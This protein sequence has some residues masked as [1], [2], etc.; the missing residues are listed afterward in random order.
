M[1]AIERHLLRLLIR[2]EL[3][4]ERLTELYQT[5]NEEVSLA[6]AGS[7]AATYDRRI[8]CR[9]VPASTEEE[10]KSK[11]IRLPEG[12]RIRIGSIRAVRVFVDRT[13]THG[14]LIYDPK[15][16]IDYSTPVENGQSYVSSHFGTEEDARAFADSVIAAIRADETRPKFVHLPDGSSARADKIESVIVRDS[17]T[18]FT[19]KPMV[20]VAFRLGGDS[21]DAL[22]FGCE[23][24][25]AAKELAEKIAADV[26]AAEAD[27]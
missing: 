26:E 1:K 5:I 17:D 24:I 14:T 4:H 6:Y 21:V 22:H 25:E 27:Q 16:S 7:E 19:G 8:D 10:M 23:T 3:R 12:G 9:R 20:C 2:R 18:S 15:V 13:N 11:F